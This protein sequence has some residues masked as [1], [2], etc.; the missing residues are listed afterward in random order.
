MYIGLTAAN[1]TAGAQDS[2]AFEI[3]VGPRWDALGGVATTSQFGDR[4]S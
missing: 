2:A 3:K 4:A 1:V